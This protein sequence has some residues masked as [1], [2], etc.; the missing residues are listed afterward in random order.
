MEI[1][2]ESMLC[3]WDETL[4]EMFVNL[5]NVIALTRNEEELRATITQFA[6]THKLDK[7]FAYG[8]GAHHLWLHQRHIS[9]TG[10]VLDN[11]LLSVHF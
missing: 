7:H 10:K 5:I 8:Y 3:N 9:D 11:R 1:R 6:Q 4:P 2:I